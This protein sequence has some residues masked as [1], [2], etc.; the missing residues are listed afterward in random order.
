M[1]K[2]LL[3]LPD[4]PEFVLSMEVRHSQNVIAELLE[5]LV[6]AKTQDL[7]ML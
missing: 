2:S 4:V 3:F 6:E 7:Q 5:V 1:I